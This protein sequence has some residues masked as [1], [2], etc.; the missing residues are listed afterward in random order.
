MGHPH[1]RTLDRLVQRQA[2][3]LLDELHQPLDL[4]RLE[5]A[6]PDAS[7]QS[8]RRLVLEER[9]QVPAPQVTVEPRR[10]RR[11]AAELV[12]RV[13]RSATER[14]RDQGVDHPRIER[15]ARD[16]DA[17]VGEHLRRPGADADRGEVRRAAAEVRDDDQLLALEPRRVARRRADRLV[18]EHGLG[19]ARL[20]ERGLH[21]RE[22]ARVV[23]GGLRAPVAHR[24]ADHATRAEIERR[25]RGT[26]EP[27][28]R[29]DHV[30]E[31]PPPAE[32]RRLGERRARQVALDRLHEPALAAGRE[33]ARDRGRARSERATG[34]EVQHRAPVSRAAQRNQ[35]DA[36]G[37]VADRDR[38]VRR[39]EVYS[40]VHRH[41]VRDRTRL[42]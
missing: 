33:V 4:A 11:L 26:H 27:Q 12:G 38:G 1:L 17:A 23:S 40:D 18:L 24:P 30:V 35:V 29:R 10:D 16:P 36:P 19:E 7:E 9:Q 42:Y 2:E 6:A 13:A 20:G 21:A 28:V 3:I 22:R 14:G 32:D 34:L 15:I 25:R 8:L 31:R 5:H 41:T 37:A 39:A